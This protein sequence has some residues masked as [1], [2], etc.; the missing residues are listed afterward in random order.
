MISGRGYRCRC[1]C[2]ERFELG[3]DKSEGSKELLQITYGHKPSQ[4]NAQLEKGDGMWLSVVGSRR[5]G[6]FYTV[7]LSLGLE[8]CGL[9]LG[10]DIICG[11]VNI[12]ANSLDYAMEGT[13]KVA[14]ILSNSY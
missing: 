6:Y 1:V 4:S 13:E 8:S 12:T 5:V 2:V 14:K 11:L 3:I 9:G 10:L 7:M